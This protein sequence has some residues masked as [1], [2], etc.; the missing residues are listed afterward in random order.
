MSARLGYRD[1]V[2]AV[3]KAKPNVWLP[4]RHFYK[5]GGACGWRTRISECRTEL[6]MNVRP[7]KTIRV[8]RADGSLKYRLS[9]YCYAPP[10]EPVA[11]PSDGH[12]LNEWSLR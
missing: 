7:N 8:R 10:A 12:D 6:H 1:A 2:A 3:F 4:S 11:V 9:L 5:P